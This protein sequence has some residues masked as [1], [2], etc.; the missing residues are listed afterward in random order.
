[1]ELQLLDR[2]S[3]LSH[4]QRMAIFRL[5]NRRYPDALPVG[6]ILDV[7]NLKPSTAS[8]Y[9]SALKSVGLIS[10]TRMGTHLLYAAN[11][12]ASQEIIS[13]LFKDCCGNRADLCLP[14]WQS[15]QSP[16]R[17]LFLC[18]GNS[19]RSIMAE[20]LLRDWPETSFTVASAG[21]FPRAE[22]NP[23]ALSILADNGHDTSNLRAKHISEFTA[24][25]TAD[26]DVVL[27]VCDNAANEDV[28]AFEGTPFSAHWSTHD[29]VPANPTLNPDEIIRKGFQNAYD[30]LHKRIA[31][32]ATIPFETANRLELQSMLDN[33]A[34]IP[35]E[36]SP[37]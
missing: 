29:P 12:E 7:L 32:F 16:I 22:P 37:K 23:I 5:L 28:G 4:P 31:E 3:A 25:N 10:Q 11:I 1:M 15:N 19:A 2:L 26:F 30:N 20:A 33:I 6:E 24:S 27:T 21:T 18:T 9:L 8:V 35:S 34:L 17:V 36:S 14:T 13:G